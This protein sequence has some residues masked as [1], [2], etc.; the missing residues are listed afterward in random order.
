VLVTDLPGDGAS[1]VDGDLAVAVVSRAGDPGRRRATAAH[2]LGHLVL[3]DEYSSDLGVSAS[4]R[5]RE[6]I[7]D[8][9]AAELLLPSPVIRQHAAAECGIRRSTLVHLAATY[10]TSWSLAV[11]QAQDAAVIDRDQ[12]NGLRSRRPTR[13]EFMEAIGWEPL[14]D[15]QSVVVP[16][17][18]ADGVMSAWRSGLITSARAVELMRDQI[19]VDDL[20][21]R[22]DTELAP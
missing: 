14:P 22:D 6:D 8:A 9:F 20:P 15:L 21:F 17:I 7:I 16:P 19:T 1:V 12:A 13:A 18:Y 11:R 5:E 4:R 3:G 2:E 10:R